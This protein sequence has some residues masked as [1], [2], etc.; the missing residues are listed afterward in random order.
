MPASPTSPTAAR[1]RPAA[2][3]AR[4]LWLA[5]L[6]AL[7]GIGPL[8]LY[9]AVGPADGNPI[10]LGLLA[11]LAVPASGGLALAALI[12]AVVERAR[13]RTGSV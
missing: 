4:L 5:G 6:V 1:R 7:L 10:G 9:I 13:R 3:A 12:A 8:L 2:R 11:M